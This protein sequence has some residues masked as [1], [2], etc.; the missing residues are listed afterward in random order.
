VPKKDPAA[1]KARQ[2]KVEAE[3]RK[4]LEALLASSF[5]EAKREEASAL[6]SSAETEEMQTY[7][8]QFAELVSM[9]WSRPP[10]A[11]NDMVTTLSVD[12]VPTGDVVGV[13]IVSS[14]GNAAFDRS[15][16]QAVLK[17]A[18]FDVPKDPR[19]FERN[20]RKFEFVFHPGDLLR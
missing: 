16:V 3:K 1:D 15:A 9:N 14:S 18:K 6:E 19:V 8:S 4:R 5:N 2:Q 11:R 10:S 7:M 12:L 13:T 17:A 20:F